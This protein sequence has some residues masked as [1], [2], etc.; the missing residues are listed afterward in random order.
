MLQCP[1]DPARPVICWTEWCARACQVC[2]CMSPVLAG[3]RRCPFLQ[4]KYVVELARAIS[5]HPAVHRVELLTRLIAD[6]KVCLCT[7]IW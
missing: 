5:L 2:M 7:T 4:V 1:Q 3:N 6:P